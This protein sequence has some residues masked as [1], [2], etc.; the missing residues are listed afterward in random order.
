[1]CGGDPR[2]SAYIRRWADFS[3]HVRGVILDQIVFFTVKFAFPR[4]CGGDPLL[5]IF[6]KVNTN[7][8]PHVRG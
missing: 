6:R 2:P 7:F 8:S 4:M 5:Y 3:P 1:M